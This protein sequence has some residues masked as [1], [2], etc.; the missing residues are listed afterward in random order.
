MLHFSWIGSIEKKRLTVVGHEPRYPEP[1]VIRR[2]DGSTYRVTD[3]QMS[4]ILKREYKYSTPER[5]K[6]AE[7]VES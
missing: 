4:R 1:W 6:A 2:E 5:F 3:E 7:E